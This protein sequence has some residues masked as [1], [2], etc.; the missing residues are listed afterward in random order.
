MTQDREKEFLTAYDSYADALFRHCY[1]RIYDRDAAKDLA[2]EAFCRTWAYL[3]EGKEVDNLRA[4]LYRV[5][6]NLIIDFVKKKK[7]VSLEGLEEKGIVPSVS[8]TEKLETNL[9]AQKIISLIESLD[10]TYRIVLTMR[11]VDDFSPKEI[12]EVL[13]LSENVV[14]VR[15]HRGI[16]KLQKKLPANELTLTP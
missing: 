7:P 12:A 1:F 14:S 2:Q 3:A 8:F 15:L 10:E 11:F 6:N 9:T 4:F 16:K 5:V 13:E